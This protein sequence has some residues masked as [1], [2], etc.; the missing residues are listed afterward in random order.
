MYVLARYLPLI[1][2]GLIGS[3]AAAQ[4]T[5]TSPTQAA[6]GVTAVQPSAVALPHSG[7]TASETEN[8]VLR[9]RLEEE[10]T[11]NSAI[12][13]TV[14]WSLGVLVTLSIALI[15]FGW[16]ANFRVYERDKEALTKALDGH[17]T[18]GLSNAKE[19]IRH[20]IEDLRQHVV[21]ETERMHVE[22]AST[23]DSAITARLADIEAK[24]ERTERAF[25]DTRLE[26]ELLRANYLFGQAQ[27][28]NAFN[29]CLSAISLAHD[30]GKPHVVHSVLDELE[31]QINKMNG[32]FGSDIQNLTTFL[33]HLDGVNPIQLA[34]LTETL[35]KVRRL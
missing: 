1:M 18:T 19:M 13:Q 12:L 24:L 25:K 8:A 14:Y 9:A 34:R 10:R 16:F 20:G 4:T 2:I 5:A 3:I 17:L 28:G 26:H 15:G 22:S 30:L 6:P 35:R 31:K 29:A 32:V 11:Y 7:Q 21:R 23:I 33:E 27:H